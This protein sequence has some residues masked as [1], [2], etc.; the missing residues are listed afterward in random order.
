VGAGRAVDTRGC[1][2]SHDAVG[3]D[4]V[5]DVGGGAA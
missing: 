1:V 5:K 4:L 2:L 3:G